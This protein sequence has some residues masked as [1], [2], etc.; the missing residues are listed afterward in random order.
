MSRAKSA[1]KLARGWQIPD[2]ARGNLPERLTAAGDAGRRHF[3]AYPFGS[4]FTEVEQELAPALQ[5]LKRLSRSRVRLLRAV[6]TGRPADWPEALA[7]MGLDRPRGL[8][9]RVLARAL[10]AALRDR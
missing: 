6:L 5:R 9:E 2:R 10:A 3:V 1:G 4:D 8:R 7:R